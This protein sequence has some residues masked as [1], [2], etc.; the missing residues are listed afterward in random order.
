MVEGVQGT[1]L[2][3]PLTEEEGEAPLEL[4]TRG[5]PIESWAGPESGAGE[6]EEEFGIKCSTLHTWVKQN[7][8][9]ALRNGVRDFVYPHEQF[10]DRMPLPGIEDVLSIAQAPRDASWRRT[11]VPGGNPSRTKL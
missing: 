7:K 10:A 11:A 4:L 9:I 2:R 5:V 8:A 6:I 1:G 3:S